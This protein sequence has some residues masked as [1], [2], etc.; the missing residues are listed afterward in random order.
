MPPLT[1]NEK[2]LYKYIKQLWGTYSLLEE[3]VKKLE[4][5]T[6]VSTTATGSPSGSSS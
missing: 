4:E 6:N 1:A 3:R 2:M 5:L